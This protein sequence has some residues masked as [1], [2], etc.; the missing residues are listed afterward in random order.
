M[1]SM[2]AMGL[3][4]SMRIGPDLTDDVPAGPLRGTRLYFL[5][6]R[7]WW[8]DPDPCRIGN[9]TSLEAA[10]LNTSWVALAGQFFLISDW[11]PTTAPEKIEV[12]KRTIAHHYGTAR[13]VDAFDRALPNTW[14]VSDE[15][16]GVR[17]DVVGLFNWEKEPLNA[18]YTLEKMGLN[19]GKTYYA[20]DFWANTP[21]PEVSKTFQADCPSRSCR[22]IALRAKEGHPVLVSTSRHVSSGT[23]EVKQERWNDNTLSGISEVVG[24]DPYELRIMGLSEDGKQWQVAEA[25]VSE[26]DK[27]AGVTVEQ[28][29]ENGL[30][31]VTITASVG[32][33]VKWQ[34]GFKN[35]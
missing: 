16:S 18:Q 15:K 30:L 23:L 2:C 35:K 17:R 34:V 5:N 10:R 6:G 22:V 8:N 33:E 9:A 21:L 12:L 27:A 3:L 29:H 14:L 25:R 24:N 7:T 13:P 32:R 28:K 11:L 31:R 1:R 4:D 26:G 20:F 19:S